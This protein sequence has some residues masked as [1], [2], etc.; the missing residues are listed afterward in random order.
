MKK[1]IISSS[2]LAIS[3]VACNSGGSGSNDNG[4]GNNSGAKQWIQV[5]SE[6]GVFL[7][8][9]IVFDPVNNLVF[10]KP[11]RNNSVCFV[12]ANAAP[13]VP[14]SCSDITINDLNWLSNIATDNAG[15]MYGFVG[16]QNN[17]VL[18]KF[19]SSGIISSVNLSN[20]PSNT[21]FS[22]IFYNNGNIYA[23]QGVNSLNNIYTNS[24]VGFN[25]TTGTYVS[26]LDSIQTGTQGLL[27]SLHVSFFGNM[28]YVESIPVSTAGNNIYSFDINNQPLVVNQY[29]SLNQVNSISANANYLYT[30]AQT[31]N[32]GESA[33]YIY[34]TPTSKAN[35]Q[36]IG[37]TSRL[38][39]N[40]K[41][42]ILGCYTVTATTYAGQNYVYA[43]GSNL[44]SGSSN[45][46]AVF[47]Q[48]K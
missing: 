31:Q 13:T 4:G 35:W 20:I 30:C 24:L 3:L 10:R 5:G 27:D 2:L 1:I 7:T 45:P 46:F 23:L 36:P 41:S 8:D 19:N 26:S 6:S 37:Y 14:W 21:S 32:A 15:N 16:T 44:T 47:T 12:A 28:L 33:T 9:S 42:V 11:S 18:I 22:S 38:N 40:G 17:P 43:T 48:P 39:M 25:P 29:Y 34:Q